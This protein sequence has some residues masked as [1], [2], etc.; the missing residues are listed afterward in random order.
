MYKIYYLVSRETKNYYI[1]MAKSNLNYRL[2]SHRHAAR[3]GKETRLYDCMREFGVDSFFMVLVDEFYTY[4]E[5]CKAEVNQI[6]S[7]RAKQHSILNLAAGGRGGYSIPESK[8][9]A[10]REKLSKARQ[11]QKPA[12]GMKHTEENKK[13]FSEASTKYWKEY[14]LLKQAKSNDLS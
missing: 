6:K 5:C 9:E 1:G 13:K 7:A 4:E 12:L 10:W 2:N 14:R 3:S 8:R 11:G